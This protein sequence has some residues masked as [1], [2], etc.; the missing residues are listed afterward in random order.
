M[1]PDASQKFS[2][3]LVVA[4]GNSSLAEDLLTELG[5]RDTQSK[6]LLLG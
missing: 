2:G 6:L 4:S 5:V 3:G 1:G